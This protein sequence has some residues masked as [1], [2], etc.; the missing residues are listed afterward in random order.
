MV[1]IVTDA[2]NLKKGGSTE[3]YSD[4]VTNDFETTVDHREEIISVAQQYFP[5][6]Q[7]TEI[8]RKQW[9]AKYLQLLLM[10]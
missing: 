2:D 3:V 8:D 1:I 7:S 6:D 4:T 10:K 9:I 5:Q